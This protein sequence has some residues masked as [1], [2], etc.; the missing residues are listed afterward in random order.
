MGGVGGGVGRGEGTWGCRGWGGV[1]GHGGCR[2]WGCRM[3][4]HGPLPYTYIHTQITAT[5]LYF[6]ISTLRWPRSKL[7]IHVPLLL[8]PTQPAQQPAHTHRTHLLVHCA[9]LL[10]TSTSHTCL[11]DH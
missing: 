9:H 2:G 10:P 6:V 7:N 8:D 3:Y 4:T 11:P 5:D 1:K